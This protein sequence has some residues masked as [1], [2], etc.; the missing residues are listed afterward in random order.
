MNKNSPEYLIL[1]K[2]L[3][4]KANTQRLSL[5]TDL[6]SQGK[7]YFEINKFL[8]KFTPGFK[9]TFEFVVQT[10]SKVTRVI[11]TDWHQK[12]MS[13]LR[14]SCDNTVQLGRNTKLGNT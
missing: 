2:L 7:P 11:L 4:M 12:W 1:L 14:L 3:V 10:K 9:T 6:S 5:R 8:P 13:D